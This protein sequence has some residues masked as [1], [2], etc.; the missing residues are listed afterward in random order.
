MTVNMLITRLLA[1][2]NQEAEVFVWDPTEEVSGSIRDQPVGDIHHPTD[3]TE[4][5]LVTDFG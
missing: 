3:G 2:E 4:V 5:Y 1:V